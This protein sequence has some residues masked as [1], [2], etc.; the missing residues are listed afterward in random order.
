MGVASSFALSPKESAVRQGAGWCDLCHHP[1]HGNSQPGIF[2][3]RRSLET[4]ISKG[5]YLEISHRAGIYFSRI[6]S[7]L[8]PH[9]HEGSSLHHL[10]P[11]LRPQSQTSLGSCVWSIMYNRIIFP[12]LLIS[13]L[14]V[15]P[16]C[17][18]TYPNYMHSPNSGALTLYFPSSVPTLLLIT[19]ASTVQ[20]A[21][22]CP[23][24][25]WPALPYAWTWQCCLC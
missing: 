6:S 2:R 12:E 5:K 20:L 3:R 7:C 11:R 24:C 13:P 22:G 15:A 8:Y 14:P 21:M 4:G 9:T 16:C 18:I 10:S 19:K 17:P 23:C 1:H 25:P